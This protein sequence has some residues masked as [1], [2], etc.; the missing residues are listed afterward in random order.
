MYLFS[1]TVPSKVNR[2]SVT[3]AVSLGR[4]ALRVIWTAPSSE[5]TITKYQVLYRINGAS[6]ITKDVKSTSTTLEKLSAGT[7]YQ[8]RVRAVSN[9]AAGPFSDIVTITTYRRELCMI[10]SACDCECTLQYKH[11]IYAILISTPTAN[12]LQ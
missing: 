5:R 9:L 7:S 1:F 6:W 8:V 12:S 4:P 11:D 10:M 2:P 3:K